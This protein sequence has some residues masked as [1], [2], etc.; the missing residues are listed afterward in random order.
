[1]ENRAFREAWELEEGPVVLLPATGV[2]LTQVCLSC[3][4]QGV[5]RGVAAG[6][7]LVGTCR[8]QQTEGTL[9]L[10]ICDAWVLSF[11]C[12][13]FRPQWLS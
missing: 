1:M 9:R 13:R 5:L 6:V 4:Q 3:R 10:L 8:L 11:T 2:P 12:E 7:L